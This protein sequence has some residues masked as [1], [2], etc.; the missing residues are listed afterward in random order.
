MR[1]DLEVS[2]LQ[3]R[4]IAPDRQPRLPLPGSEERWPEE[5]WEEL[6]PEVQRDALH[7]L[8][9]LLIRWLSGLEYRR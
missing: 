4:S 5:V 9:R 3:L 1:S 6:P 2:P 7:Y 8:A